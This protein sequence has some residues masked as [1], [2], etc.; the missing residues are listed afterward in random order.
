MSQLYWFTGQYLG[1]AG[2]ANVF[3]PDH[4]PLEDEKQFLPAA[5]SWFEPD[6]E[7]ITENHGTMK[8]A[9]WLARKNGW[10][11]CP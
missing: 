7:A 8:V 1:R 11:E 9:S 4:E 10:T 6:P 5:H 2:K 3:L